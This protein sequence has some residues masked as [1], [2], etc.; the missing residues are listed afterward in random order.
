ME[1]IILKN[2]EEVACMGAELVGELLYRSGA[3]VS[4]ELLIVDQVMGCLKIAGTQLK[5]IETLN[6]P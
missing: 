5:E 2:S 1:I 3:A 4:G 6:N